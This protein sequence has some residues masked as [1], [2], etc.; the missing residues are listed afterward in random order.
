[1]RKA[2]APEGGPRSSSA[3]QLQWVPEGVRA[4]VRGGR[5]QLDRRA[6]GRGRGFHGD[7]AALDRQV[8]SPHPVNVLSRDWPQRGPTHQP[9]W[10]TALDGEEGNFCR[11][12]PGCP[13]AP[14]TAR[15]YCGLDGPSLESCNPRGQSSLWPPPCVHSAPGPQPSPRQGVWGA[16]V[17]GLDVGRFLWSSQRCRRSPELPAQLGLI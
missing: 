8:P 15:R 4:A 2:L 9:A 10:A 14:H 7:G 12:P 1:M 11:A 17:W 3:S 6:A 16:G 13:P 5:G